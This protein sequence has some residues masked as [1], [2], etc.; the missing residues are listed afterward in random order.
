MVMCSQ[1]KSL[2]WVDNLSLTTGIKPEIS[3][4]SRVMSQIL[5]LHCL[6]I[7]QPEIT[8][9]PHS[10]SQ[11]VKLVLAIQVLGTVKW[12]NV[13]NGYKLINMIDTKEDVF[14]H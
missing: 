2:S 9:V 8:S 7:A 10:W 11:D 14:V 3:H 13:Q 5:P 4:L 1:S 6:K 12:F